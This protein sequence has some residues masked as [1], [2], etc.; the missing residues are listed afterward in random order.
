[1]AIQGNEK[2]KAQDLVERIES[3]QFDENDV[4]AI[5]MKLRAHCGSN[6]YF[7][8]IGDFIAHNDER[9]KG[10][11]V[12]SLEALHL[13]LRFFYDY[14]TSRKQFD[15]FSPFPVYVKKHMKYQVEKCDEERLRKE[16]H[17]TRQRL[18]SN[19]DSLF[20]DDKI[21]KT[22]IARGRIGQ[23]THDAL[24][25]AVQF[26]HIRHAFTQR[27]LLDQTISVLSENRL[28]CDP[29][30]FAKSFDKV[31]LCILV[32]LHNTSF[33]IKASQP[34]RCEVSCKLPTI[35]GPV[36]AVNDRGETETI[37]QDFGHLHVS[38]EVPGIASGGGNF[39]MKYELFST[40]LHVTDWCDESLFSRGVQNGI[41]YSTVD[42]SGQLGVGENSK[43]RNF[44][45]A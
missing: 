27:D 4:D 2:R 34:A 7:R 12:E 16:F 42:L 17:T 8:E 9:H 20:K 32:L 36:Q 30:R 31:S 26:L 40:S 25:Y 43:L 15:L 21:T 37:T 13:S 19:I 23:E 22:T 35:W 18:K 14:V 6:Q 44:T 3:G 38:G 45:E 29:D 5:F 28:K 33:N 11:T 1:M 24:L 10:I 41:P 39:T